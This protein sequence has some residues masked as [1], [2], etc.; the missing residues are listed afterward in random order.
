M[1]RLNGFT[2]KQLMDIYGL[3]VLARELDNKMLIY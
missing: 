1:A 3:M 2:K